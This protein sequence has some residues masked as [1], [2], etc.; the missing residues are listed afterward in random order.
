MIVEK[1][2]VNGALLNVTGEG[3]K[4]KG[5]FFRGDTPVSKDMHLHRLLVTGTLCNDAGLVEKEGKW[6][7][8]GDPTGRGSRSR[9]S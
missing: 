3:Y 7:I 1:V 9:R 6:D 8:I 5:D 4:P 2:Y